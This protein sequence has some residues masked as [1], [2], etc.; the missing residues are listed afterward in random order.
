MY[1]A[2]QQPRFFQAFGGATRFA[3][4]L[5]LALCLSGGFA[6]AAE[7]KPDL[8]LPPSDVGLEEAATP[9][10]ELWRANFQST[11]VWQK[12]P[13]FSAA[14]DG[15]NSLVHTAESGY[16]LT[17]TLYLGLHPWRG[18][19]IFANPE[20]IQSEELSKLHGLGGFSNAENQKS[21]GPKASL[22][23]ARAFIRQTINLG[24]EASV[25]AAGPNQFAT[26]DASRRLVIS[27][28]QMAL[29]DIFDNNAYSHDGRTQ[30]MNWMFMAYGASDYAAD[31]RGYTW[32]LAIEYYFDDWALRIGRFAQPKESNG[33]SMD[34][35]L[36]QHY[37]DNLEI[38]HD[39]TLGSR[40]GKVRLMGIHNY[41]KMGAFND[42]IDDALQNGGTPAFDNIRRDQ[43]KFAFGLSF[44]QALTV[45][46]GLFGR[47]SWNDG[48]TETYAF[49]EVDRSVTAGAVMRGR[50]WRRPDDTLGLGMAVE[51]ISDAHRAYLARGGLGAFLGDGQLANYAPERIL[52]IYYSLAAARGFWAS[53]GYQWIGNPAYNADRGPVSVFSIRFH[54]EY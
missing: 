50:T 5:A 18:T 1:Q 17:A 14:Y 28:G 39:H 3:L 8:G 44:E 30:F 35:K 48:R 46:L 10:P 36:W 45:D 11:Y 9:S 19:E 54:A 34:F 27:A 38:E 42:A 22:Y 41:A 31:A 20:I 15:P 32:G 7:K 13:G 29:V 12:H 47:A 16:T 43:S 37:G 4:V 40:P 52:E 21:G 25:A 53:A 26:R 2:S 23:S 51:G 6:R 49:T 33:L 24:G